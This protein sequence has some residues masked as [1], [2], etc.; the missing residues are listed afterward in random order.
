MPLSATCG[1]LLSPRDILAVLVGFPSISSSSNLD[2][3]AWVEGYLASHDI[4]AHR[5]YN[6]DGSKAAI[7]AH[8]GPDQAGGVLLSGHSDVV[9][10]DGQVWRSDPWV[11][12][13]EAGRLYGRGACD[14]KAFDALAIWAM[15]EA[16][17]RGV[18]RP[19]QLAL[20][21][22]EEPGCLGAPP[23]IEAMKQVLPQ[24]SVAIIGEPSRMACVTAHKGGVGF[25]VD[26]T[27]VAM[28]SSLLPDSV[29]AVMEAARLVN[30]INDINDESAALPVTEVASLFHPALST[31]HVGQIQ[32]GTAHNITA[33][34]CH[35]VT[36]FRVL[37]DQSIDGWIARFEAET[38]ALDAKLRAK[39]PEAAVRLERL[40]SLPPLAP[41]P[42]GQAEALV[43]A[44]TGDNQTHVVSYGTEAGQF[45]VA[46]Y[47]AVVCGPGDIAQAHQAD[48]YIEVSQLDA[49]QAFMEQLLCRLV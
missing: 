28:H 48:E 41:E 13:E 19:L 43:R 20:S 39:R 47:S 15:V 34:D 36:E 46:G 40:F 45:Q 5:F 17:R 22:D 9:P 8:V 24:A 26:V 7:F 1:G 42:A 21:Y 11:L 12:T 30:W 31:F 10:V 4:R 16:R 6:E 27:G 2:L 44:I 23:M 38:A 33:K 18:N 32:G 35:F 29:S 3:V 49:G 37:P 14:M 25:R